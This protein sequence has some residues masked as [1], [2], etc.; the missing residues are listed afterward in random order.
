M[1]VAVIGIDPDSK[2][3][4]A[5]VTVDDARPVLRQKVLPTNVPI[6]RVCAVAYKWTFNLVAEYHRAGDV[7]H[8]FV[9]APFVSPKTIRAVI[10]LA[11]LNGAM[12][13]AGMSARAVT[14]LDVNIT[15][16]K[17]EVVGKGNAS[18]PQIADWCRDCWPMVY[19]E[20]AGRQDLLDAAGIN[21][22]GAGVVK[23]QKRLEEFY[24]SH[25]DE[26]PS[27]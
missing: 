22:Y 20:A 4:S 16:W 7:V 2:K 25:P 26:V 14:V 6:A 11:R 12:L 9:E 3:L 13:A 10:P 8:L 27:A 18:K 19:E 17:K 5:V 24:A 23:R 1:G 15:S 21:R